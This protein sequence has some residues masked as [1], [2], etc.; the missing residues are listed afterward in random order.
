MTSSISELEKIINAS[1]VGE[2]SG[3][4]D[5]NRVELAK[6]GS[7]AERLVEQL[8]L[9]QSTHKRGDGHQEVN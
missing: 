5:G 7:G 1:K 3:E 8:P 6:S 4:W 2:P 9:E